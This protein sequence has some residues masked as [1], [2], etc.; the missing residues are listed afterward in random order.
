MWMLDV[1]C[2]ALGCVLL[3]LL[4]KAREASIVAEESEQV[5]RELAR[6]QTALLETEGRSL[7]LASDIVDRDDKLALL[8]IERDEA[9]RQLALVRQDRDEQARQLALARQKL[10]AAAKALALV[11]ESVK[12]AEANLALTRKKSDETEKKLALAQDRTTQTQDELAKRASE[13]DALAKKLADSKKTQDDL[14]R[15]LRDQEKQ[16]ADALRQSLDLSDRLLAADAKAAAA[17]KR[18]TEIEKQVADAQVQIVDLQGTKAKL[19]DKLDKLQIESDQR[20][21]GIAMTGRNV[22]F[23]VDM[24]G[25]MDRVDENTIDPGKWPIVRDTLLKVMRSLPDLTQFQVLLFSSKTI[26]M[27]GEEGE[28]IKYEKEKSLEQVRQ[29]MTATKPVGDTN[30][31]AA[32]NEAFKFRSKGMDTIYLISDGLPT[33]G[34][35][36]TTREQETITSEAERGVIL[37]RHLRR[38]LKTLWNGPGSTP[39]VRVNA[40]GFFYESP[41]VGAFLW[42][43]ARENDGS[44]VGMSRP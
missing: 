19:A 28:W 30:L 39:R 2:C 16:R 20:F 43:L 33:S 36:L 13:I 42:A 14:A 9:A 18:V 3:L 22:V 8:M 35:G 4:L 1:F 11:E 34:P 10:D 41:E 26:T 15:L 38:T 23:M 21:A 24:S 44:F 6:T 12:T 7:L 5:A 40:V 37:A 27:L 25:S 29:R 17:Q 32:F 31:Y